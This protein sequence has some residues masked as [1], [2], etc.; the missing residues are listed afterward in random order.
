MSLTVLEAGEH[1]TVVALQG[2]LDATTVTAIQAD[3]LKETAGRKKSVIVDM[4][5]IGFMASLGIRMLVEAAKGLRSSGHRLVLLKPQ[6]FVERTIV[7][8]GLDAALGVTHDEAEARKLLG[9]S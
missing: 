7:I 1:V 8:S 9:A 6:P 5:Q 2:K 4:S 3:F